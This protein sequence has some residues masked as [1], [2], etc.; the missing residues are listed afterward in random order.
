M[1]ATTPST[2]LRD[3]LAKHGGEP[4]DIVRVESAGDSGTGAM[5]VLFLSGTAP[6]VAYISRNADGGVEVEICDGW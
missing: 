6:K 3:L 2:E 4:T 5:E 1:A